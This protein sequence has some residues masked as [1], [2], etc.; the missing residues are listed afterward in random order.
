MLPN[1]VR[2]TLGQGHKRR[3]IDAWW[4]LYGAPPDEL[5]CC[6]PG[7]TA[8][9]KTFHCPPRFTIWGWPS[10]PQVLWHLH[11]E[12]SKFVW[13]GIVVTSDR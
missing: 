11:G 1:I 7:D 2:R 8:P 5:C 12:N 3:A 6:G 13:N 9:E 10:W 4:L